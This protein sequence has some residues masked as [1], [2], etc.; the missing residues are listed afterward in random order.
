M[1]T[2]NILSLQVREKEQD[3]L[4]SRVSWCILGLR[5]IWERLPK[6]A[7]HQ[8][9]NNNVSGGI[10]DEQAQKWTV[11]LSRMEATAFG[12]TAVAKLKRLKNLSGAGALYF[13]INPS[14]KK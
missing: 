2:Y 10:L 11:N 6:K 4:F 8:L 3:V 14:N 12:S 9:E 5:E 7:H 1:K 13:S